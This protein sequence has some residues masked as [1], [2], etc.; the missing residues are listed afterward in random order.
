MCLLKHLLGCLFLAV[1]CR[2]GMWLCSRRVRALPQLLLPL[3]RWPGCAAP[4]WT[5]SWTRSAPPRQR[6]RRSSVLLQQ[7]QKSRH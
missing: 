2:Q 3:Q 6:W 1:T 5:L 4:C 7:R